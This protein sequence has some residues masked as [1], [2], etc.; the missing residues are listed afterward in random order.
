MA[1][2]ILCEGCQQKLPIKENLM[3]SLCKC[4]YD[5][6]CAGVIKED[7]KL[8]SLEVRNSW[9]CQKCVCKI[10]KTGNTDTPIHSRKSPK[11]NTPS[12]PTT[13][14]NVTMRKK[15]TNS[16][17]DTANSIDL[18]ILGDTLHTEDNINTET[19]NTSFTFD[20]TSLLNSAQVQ[21][22]MQNLSELIILRLKENNKS[23]IKELQNTI[24]IEIT[25]A[26][27]DLK[28][29]LD[30]KMNTLTSQNE[31]RKQE[32]ENINTKVETLQLENERLKKELR[33]LSAKTNQTPSIPEN[34]H[35]KIVLY[36]LTENF[37]EPECALYNKLINLFRDIA[38]V[39]LSGYIEDMYRVGK[40]GLRNRPLVIE[41]LSK[42]MTRYILSCKQYFQGTGLGVS[43]FLDVKSRKERAQMRDE[44]VK[45]R[46]NGYHAI[47]RNN[48]LYING[49]LVNKNFN[50]IES[51][52]E[53]MSSQEN[54]KNMLNSTNLS[55]HADIPNESINCTF[56][57]QR[58]TIQNIIPELPKPLQ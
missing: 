57:N 6:E 58:T 55:H 5:I 16:I 45:A 44:L 25:R 23:I 41:L 40:K 19:E 36:G 48:Q 18:S 33:E 12:S 37:Q 13:C 17:N 46:K 53:D 43:E 21:L 39:N 47:I 29:E 1:P 50:N 54:D 52:N 22:N 32:I 28:L 4:R 10:P 38:N 11:Y 7:L 56:R 42:R 8:M 2:T 34:H 24:Q 20:S 26:I 31:E 14:S 49:K 27:T 51:Q 9:K 30:T 15:T 3:C 35:H